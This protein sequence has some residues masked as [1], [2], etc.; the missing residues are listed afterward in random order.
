MNR[1]I[2]SI[3]TVNVIVMV[4][5]TVQSVYSFRGM[6]SE[7]DTDSVG[8]EVKF[9][10]LIR[11]EEPT[12]TDEQLDEYLDEGMYENDNAT[13]IFLVWSDKTEVETEADKYEMTYGDEVVKFH[14]F[15]P[16]AENLV[17]IRI[18][19]GMGMG[20]GI[21]AC[22]SDEDKKKYDDDT[23][24][25]SL[26]ACTLRNDSVNGIGWGTYIVAQCQGSDRPVCVL[27]KLSGN[28]VRNTQDT[29]GQ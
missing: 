2:Q 16:K 19:G 12:I 28:I 15:T 14:D 23:D 3:P 21:W 25:T 9:K 8:A 6:D 1:T 26:I 24:T 22:V 17:K 29:V 4:D 11:N 7:S 5:N 20:E 18:E 10:E 27:E 13:Q